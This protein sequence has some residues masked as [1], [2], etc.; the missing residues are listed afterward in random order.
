MCLWMGERGIEEIGMR[1]REMQVNHEKQPLGCT[2]GYPVFSWITEGCKGKRQ[3]Q[4]RMRIFLDSEGKREVYDSDWQQDIKSTAFCPNVQLSPRTRYFW[5]VQVRTER[6]EKITSPVSWFETGKEQETWYGTWLTPEKTQN[7]E[8]AQKGAGKHFF[9]PE[10]LVSARLYLCTRGNPKIFINKKKVSNGYRVLANKEEEIPSYMIHNVTSFLKKGKENVLQFWDGEVLGELHMESSTGRE[11]V[12][13]TEETWESVVSDA[14]CTEK[15]GE[16]EP[17]D[18][19]DRAL[20]FSKFPEALHQ[21]ASALL[22][23][24][25]YLLSGDE[26]QLAEQ[27]GTMQKW[28][29]DIHTV[30]KALC[31]T[32]DQGL[33]SAAVYYESILCTAKAAKILEIR[34]DA[35]Y[36]KKLAKEVKQA[37][38]EAY[39]EKEEG[40]YTQS[41]TARILILYW[42]LAPEKMQ[43]QLLEQVKEELECSEMKIQ[44]EEPDWIYGILEIWR[45]SVVCGLKPTATGSGF[46]RVVLAPKPERSMKGAS[47]TY[48]SASGTYRTSWKWT[49]D[50]IV[51]HAVI[52]FDAK[53]RFVFPFV[54]K[55]IK[56][57]GK[58]C[59][60]A[61]MPEKLVLH[62]GT[63]EIEMKLK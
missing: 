13:A 37:F 21:Y 40:P 31:G 20:K 22:P 63:Y 9:V 46:K 39:L 38:S 52:P 57:N 44:S 47:C 16:Q 23:W 15:K 12:L 43:K 10:D 4:A 61:E 53:A 29:E 34:E 19:Q 55:Q 35:A 2:C 42:N 6:G 51:F 36:Y 62:A 54:G 11:N 14:A 32:A 5:L 50:G 3:K 8:S 17:E 56:V 48:E 18:R 49:E 30:D 26:I 27:Y 1:I 24:K 33:V 7:Q 45:Y 58:L 28:V 25:Q 59:K 41:L 60:E